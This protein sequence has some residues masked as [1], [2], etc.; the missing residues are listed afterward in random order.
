M[1]YPPEHKEASRAALVA[2]SGALAKAEGFA[3]TGLQALVGAAGVTTGAFY[4]QFSGKDELLTA[5]VEH[6]IDRI[7]P[8]FQGQTP[9]GLMQVLAMYLSPQHA[10]HPGQ[11]CAIP[12]LGPEIARADAATRQAFEQRIVQV[13]AAVADSLGDG[14]AAWGVIAQAVGAVVIARA[15]ASRKGRQEVLAAALGQARQAV[16]RAAGAP[17]NG[18][19][20]AGVDD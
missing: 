17:A 9:A 5:I 16:A 7:L 18:K 3:G 4:S 14:D 10:D 20:K 2:A 13:H 11:G 6:E 1:R 15:M 8:W 12:A 19:G